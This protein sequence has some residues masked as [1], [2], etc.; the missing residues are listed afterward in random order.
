MRLGRPANIQSDLWNYT[1]DALIQKTPKYKE[2]QQVL[3]NAVERYNQL[4]VQYEQQQQQ[5]RYSASVNNTN[6]NIDSNHTATNTNINHST[7][8]TTTATT[9]SNNI[10]EVMLSYA[11][12]DIHSAKQVL[13]D[14]EDEFAEQVLLQADVVV[15]TCVGA[16]SEVLKKFVHTYGIEYD[17][18]LMDEAAQV[19]HV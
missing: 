1:L 11:R 14:R 17:T 3:D 19:S 15:C 8:T 13:R 2:C 16:G 4:L 12:K 10:T 5:Q 18:V 7:T 6:I 9:P